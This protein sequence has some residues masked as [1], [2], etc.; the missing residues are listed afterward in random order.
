MK[1]I[2]F[3]Q[4]SSYEVPMWGAVS[5]SFILSMK[6]KINCSPKLQNAR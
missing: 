1:N 5:I 6:T 4:I 3:I 2:P